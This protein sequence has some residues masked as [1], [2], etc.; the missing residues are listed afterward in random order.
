MGKKSPPIPIIF[1][2]DES[3]TFEHTFT[4]GDGDNSPI[5]FYF[6][7]PPYAEPNAPYAFVQTCIQHRNW[8]GPFL[9]LEGSFHSLQGLEY[10]QLF[11]SGILTR[12][13]RSS[14]AI[15]CVLE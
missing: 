12:H 9:L 1:E 11:S 4:N 7:T 14:R 2:D 10:D 8:R 15:R 13:T 5:I 3:P 6:R